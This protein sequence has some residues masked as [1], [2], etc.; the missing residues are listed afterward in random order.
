MRSFTKVRQRLKSRRVIRAG[1][2]RPLT[3]FAAA[4]IISGLLLNSSALA[5]Q[6]PAVPQLGHEAILK[7]R[8]IVVGEPVPRL[9]APL[10]LT[11]PQDRRQAIDAYWGPG[12][13][14]ADK[15]TLFD[16]FWQYAD[17]KYAAFQGVNVDWAALRYQYR[18]E[19]AAGVSRG[20]FAGIMNHLSVALRD[21]HTQAFDVPVNIVS[22]PQPGVPLLALS[23]WT[24]DTAGVCET[25]LEDGSALVYA[26]IPGH[27]MGLEPGDRILGYDGRPYRDLYRQLLDEDVPLWPLWWGSSPSSF[28]H[29]FVMAAAMNWPF[30]QTMDIAKHGTGKV[31]HVPTSNMPGIIWY[32][33][34]SEQL[35]VAGVPTPPDFYNGEFVSSGIVAGTNFGYIYVWGW[36]GT[37]EQ[38]FAQAVNQLT[39]V[40]HVDGLIIDFRFNNGGFID[41]PLLG[42]AE[43]A[44]HPTPTIGYDERKPGGGHFAMTDLYPPSQFLLDF[45]SDGSRVKTSYYGPIAVLV[46]P[47]AVSAGDLGAFWT[48]FLPRARTFGKSTSAAF[49]IP[50]QDSLGTSLNL[51][52]DWYTRVGEANAWAV[53]APFQYLTHREFPVDQHVW[54]KPDD[55]AVGRDTVVE[56]ALSWL[57]KQRYK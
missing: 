43:L 15:L 5:Q 26:A 25:A 41:A 16:Q 6:P 54:L 29:S 30:F 32:G 40:Q 10:S 49:T 34:C 18:R 24:Y 38:D 57:Q 19:I 14:T 47:G 9:S 20:R 11:S 53:S 36:L 50:T 44:S 37:A 17:A 39:Q 56:A 42:I 28:D 46:G 31:V 55:V 23:A 21:S 33:F 45:A 51:N 4:T 48:T 7:A 35:P 3:A 12:L 22:V 52:P 1:S 27:P 2:Q 8:A 13:S